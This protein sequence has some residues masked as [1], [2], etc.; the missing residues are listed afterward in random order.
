M[1]GK[2]ELGLANVDESFPGFFP[3]MS[4]CCVTCLSLEDTWKL[5][6]EGI[7]MYYIYTMN[8]YI[9]VIYRVSYFC[10]FKNKPLR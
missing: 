6:F 1:F 4:W 10:S 9:Y 7:T 8:I 3:H 2:R 5:Q